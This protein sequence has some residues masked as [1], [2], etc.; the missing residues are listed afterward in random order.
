MRYFLG[1]GSNLG[2]RLAYLQAAAA[3]LVARGVP[4][5]RSSCVYETTPVGALD[6][7]PNYL[8]AV[9]E[10]ESAQ[11]P[12]ELLNVTHEL[13]CENGRVRGVRN[14]A[15]TLDIDILLAEDVTCK[16]DVLTVPHPRMHERLFVLTPLRELAPAAMHPVFQQTI[17]A[18]YH[19]CR[20][21]SQACVRLFAPPFVLLNARGALTT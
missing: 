3:G 13:E 4:V 11:Q 15:R 21:A 9:L 12:D 18:L 20:A 7:Q 17:D 6:A 10:C 14:A 16:T 5:L 19:A 8:N 2:E 1:I